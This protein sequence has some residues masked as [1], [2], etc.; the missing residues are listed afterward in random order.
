MEAEIGIGLREFALLQ[1]CSNLFKLSTT[2]DYP[3]PEDGRTVLKVFNVLGQECE[4]VDLRQ[5][6]IRLRQKWEVDAPK[7][8]LMN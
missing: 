5:R 1:N 7:R 8:L 6:R 2:I 4:V 3:R